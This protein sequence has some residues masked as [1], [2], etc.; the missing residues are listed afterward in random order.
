M[1][2]LSGLYRLKN[3]TNVKFGLN[4]AATNS[5]KSMCIIHKRCLSPEFCDRK[6]WCILYRNVCDTRKMTTRNN[7]HSNYF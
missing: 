4:L 2:I 5:K 1:F 6:L 3:K 7:T